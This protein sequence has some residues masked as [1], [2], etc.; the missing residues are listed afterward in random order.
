MA[1][2]IE[3]TKKYYVYSLQASDEDQ[4][5][6]I[7]K[8][9]KGSKRLNEHKASSK[10]PKHRTARKI[11]SILMRGADII[12]TEIQDF[13]DEKDCINYE[14]KMI[15]K[16]GF[17]DNGGILT[18]N[19]RG[20]DGASGYVHTPESK[21]KMSIMKR[22]NKISLGRKREDTRLLKSKTVSSYNLNGDYIETFSSARDAAKHYNINFGQISACC[23]GNINTT[24][25][26]NNKGYIRFKFGD[27]QEKL[28]KI[29]QNQSTKGTI[30]QYD[31][32]GNEIKRFYNANRASEET[33]IPSGYIRACCNGVQ[34]TA[35]GY[36]W[37]II[38]EQ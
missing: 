18:N 5:F 28:E 17:K 31:L 23:L 24:K 19:T 25:L 36:I 7:G 30:I 2:D 10:K 27:S 15:A 13:E 6:Y 8:T 4:I 3:Q 21:K 33:S 14:I 16:Y 12:L 34:K 32:D 11:Q 9:F 1:K 37:K 20:G 22:G 29:I 35:G 26:P 38:K